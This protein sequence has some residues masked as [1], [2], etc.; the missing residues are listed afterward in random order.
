MSL[1]NARTLARRNAVQ[2]IYQWQITHADLSEIER[3]FVEEHGLG[4]ADPEYFSELLHTIPSRLDEIDRALVEFSD[5]GVEEI[6][7]VERAVLRIGCYELMFRPD[8]PYRVALNEGVNL[9]KAFGAAHSHK[10]ING[11]L[12]K[13]AHK[14]LPDEISAHRAGRL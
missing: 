10:Y 1:S 6:D 3:Q 9:A 7:P 8:I 5:R 13:I 11:I 12:D 4:K 2:A 14:R